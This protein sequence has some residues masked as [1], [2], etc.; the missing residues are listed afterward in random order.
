MACILANWK[1]LMEYKVK[2]QKIERPINK[3]FC[4]AADQTVGAPR[5]NADRQTSTKIFITIT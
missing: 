4:L 3:T 2:L 5:E 1:E